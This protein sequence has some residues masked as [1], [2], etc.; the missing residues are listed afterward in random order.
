MHREAAERIQRGD[1]QGAVAL[2]E[3]Y[4]KGNPTDLRALTLLGM[5][6]SAAGRLSEANESFRRVLQ[7]DAQFVPALQGLALNEIALGRAAEARR[8]L[9]QLLKI[10]PT[11]PVAHLAMG[12]LAYV[13][14][15]FPAVVAHYDRSGGLFKTDPRRLLNYAQAL[16]ESNQPDA[17]KAALGDLPAEVEATVQFEA[18]LLLARLGDYPGAAARFEKARSNYPDRYEVEYNLALAYQKGNQ[19]AEAVRILEHLAA[20]GPDKAELYNLLGHAYRGA[21]RIREAYEAFRK[22]ATL[23]PEDEANY[24]DLIALCLDQNNPD[25]ASEI[26]DIG[27]R[28]RPES[29]RLW[30]QKGVVYAWKGL[31]PQAREAFAKAAELSKEMGLA[32]VALG[33]ALLQMNE[34]AAAIE[35]LRQRAQ[36]DDYLAQWFLAEALYRSGAPPGS[37]EEQEAIQALEKSVRSKP[38]LAPSRALLGKLLFRRGDFEGAAAQLE[39]ALEIAP[40]DVS[41]LYQLAQLYAKKGDLARSRELF[42][43][44]GKMKAN[45]REQF[46]SQGLEQI[47]RQ[48]TR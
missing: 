48:G 43:R 11:N 29:G 3:P 2:L 14:K 21:G 28:R 33:L 25:L 26:A 41:A 8:H 7:V 13:A 39:R 27:L 42:A 30:I 1:P 32:H 6:F 46:T 18:G 34:N 31:M 9:E 40:D 44:V 10:A 19:P 23:E 20:S 24:L 17:A 16:A 12:D 5:A 47:L 36:Q 15:D 38:D 35:L 22:A 45:E 4:I 37:A